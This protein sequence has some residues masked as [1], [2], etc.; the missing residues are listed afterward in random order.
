MAQPVSLNEAKLFLR[1]SHDSEDSLISTF[2]EA[3]VA[4][5]EQLTGL[6]L[7]ET[8]PAPLRLCVLYGLFEAYTG[9]GETQSLRTAIMALA[10]PYCTVRL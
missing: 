8:S 4:S 5:I 1:L 7:S 6:V 2:L 9:R 10:A 3:S